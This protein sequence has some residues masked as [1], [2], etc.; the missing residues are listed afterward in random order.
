VYLV[1]NWGLNFEGVFGCKFGGKVLASGLVRS[2]AVHLDEGGLEYNLLQRYGRINIMIAEMAAY[3]LA[4]NTKISRPNNTTSTQTPTLKH[5]AR[6]ITTTTTT[7]IIT[8]IIITITITWSITASSLSNFSNVSTSLWNHKVSQFATD[9]QMQTVSQFAN[10]KQTHTMS[11]Y[12][13]APTQK[14]AQKQNARARACSG[15]MP[16]SNANFNT[17]LI[18]TKPN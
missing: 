7:I 5:N 18:W 12:A 11:H 8:I 10:D 2:C 4:I 9:K 17:S 13:T 15:S 16:I 14:R 1:V 3:I 6:C